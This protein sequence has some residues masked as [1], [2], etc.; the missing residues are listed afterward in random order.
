MIL[1]D[2]HQNFNL[3]L[4]IHLG[5]HLYPG[6]YQIMECRDET[7]AALRYRDYIDKKIILLNWLPWITDVVDYSWADLCIFFTTE[8][9][10]NRDIED[11]EQKI[12]AQYNVINFLIVCAGTASMSNKN[13]KTDPRIYYKNPE[14]F[15]RVVCANPLYIKNKESNTKMFDALLGVPKLHRQ[16]IFEKIKRYDLMDQG[17]ISIQPMYEGWNGNGP[18]AFDAFY[19]PTGIGMPNYQ[20]PELEHLEEDDLKYLKKSATDGQV[21]FSSPQ[22]PRLLPTCQVL[23]DSYNLGLDDRFNQDQYRVRR[24][25]E[26]RSAASQVIPRKIY[27]ASWYSIVS[28]TYACDTMLS[29]KIAKC[30]LARRVFVLFGN[31]D[32]FKALTDRGFRRFGQL[33]LVPCASYDNWPA[34]EKRFLET[35]NYFTELIKLD[36]HAVYEEAQEVLDH[37][38]RIITD[39]K[40]PM[41]KLATWLH[42][43][44]Q[45]RNL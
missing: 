8:L 43:Q 42:A 20:S 29:E 36:P 9:L 19:S 7:N 33:G 15:S 28:E 4:S 26:I 40:T 16:H 14:T 25:H 24:L 2:L 18:W 32:H 6:E 21:Y 12:L 35:W 11:L 44:I 37:N 45:S 31:H 34:V 22:T 30:L 38:F 13:L 23:N 5:T 10:E 1:I 3:A 39:I 27:D 41:H 17:L